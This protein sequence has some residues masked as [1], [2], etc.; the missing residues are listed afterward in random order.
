MQAVDTEEVHTPKVTL[1]VDLSG[2][3]SQL[4]HAK[5]SEVLKGRSPLLTPVSAKAETSKNSSKEPVSFMNGKQVDPVGRDY[6]RS[7]ST[8]GNGKLAE[9]FTTCSGEQFKAAAV[10][11]NGVQAVTEFSKEQMKASA[12]NS[13]GI[14]ADTLVGF[15]VDRMKTVKD[16]SSTQ[17]VES[18]LQ[19]LRSAHEKLT[20]T[21]APA[22][23]ESEDEASTLSDDYRR[24]VND[25]QREKEKI[26]PDWSA[27]ALCDLCERGPALSLGAWYSWCC[28]NPSNICD[29]SY[30]DQQ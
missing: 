28:G 6:N 7:V 25:G 17:H 20:E 21:S 29:C 1:V 16:F 11:S 26:K 22:A 13:S 4:K 9:T 18:G 8:K 14:Q 3:V 10:Y 30:D 23:E 19:A 5:V 2:A 12:I 24:G 27:D 15:S